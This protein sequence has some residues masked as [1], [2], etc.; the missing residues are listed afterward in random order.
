MVCCSLV[1]MEAQGRVILRTCVAVTMG[2]VRALAIVPMA[3]L[4]APAGENHQSQPANV[5]IELFPAVEHTSM[6]AAT[7][8]LV[9]SKLYGQMQPLEVVLV[10]VSQILWLSCNANLRFSA[11]GWLTCSC[12][13]LLL[14]TVT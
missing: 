1:G 14:L 6:F 2:A 12:S 7:V 9:P 3:L 4:Y 13:K 5:H 11:V 8:L 10:S